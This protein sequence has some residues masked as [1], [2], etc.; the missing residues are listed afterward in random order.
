MRNEFKNSRTSNTSS[1]INTNYFCDY[2]QSEMKI[3]IECSNNKFCSTKCKSD[4][5]FK[6]CNICSIDSLKNNFYLYN[7]LFYCSKKCLK[8]DDLLYCDFCFQVQCSSHFIYNDNLNKRCYDCY[9]KSLEISHCLNCNSVESGIN[10]NLIFD[11]NL[12]FCSTK[13]YFSSILNGNVLK[14]CNCLCYFEK[15]EINVLKYNFSF[16]D[17][18]CYNVFFNKYPNCDFS[19]LNSNLLDILK[20]DKAFINNNDKS[21][22]KSLLTNFSCLTNDSSNEYLKKSYMPVFSHCDRLK[23]LYL[24]LK[25]SYC[26]IVSLCYIY[27][28]DYDTNL[29]LVYDL[30]SADLINE[31]LDFID[32]DSLFELNLFLE[33]NN[34]LLINK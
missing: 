4:F 5:G 13:C 12:N 10:S 2:C 29:L 30:S 23:S 6:S 28:F 34:Y 7:N 11:I 17:K 20:Y 33:L 3:P 31:L 1:L 15:N 16:C 24:L 21:Y 26:I 14:C 9:E 19:L 32:N 27:K 18:G 25:K 8:S 22:S